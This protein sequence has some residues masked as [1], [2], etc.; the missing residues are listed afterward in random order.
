MM[1]D[2]R[3]LA[4][5]VFGYGHVAGRTHMAVSSLEGGGQNERFTLKRITTL[6]PP[7]VCSDRLLL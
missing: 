4:A 1:W 2:E 7:F 6:P 3:T 5:W